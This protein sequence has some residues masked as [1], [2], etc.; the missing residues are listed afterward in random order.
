MKNRRG[1]FTL[2]ELM[3]VIVVIAILAGIIFSVLNSSRNNA[4]DK[5]RSAARMTIAAGVV[6]YKQRF[7][8]WPVPAPGPGTYSNNNF[9]VVDILTSLPEPLITMGA[10]KRT[11]NG[12]LVDPYGRCYVIRFDGTNAYV[13][14]KS[15]SD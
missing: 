7:M 10:Y 6:S 12:S 13:D 8:K 9:L 1:G 11:A 2:I 15:V 4:R 5:Q 14:G 3:I